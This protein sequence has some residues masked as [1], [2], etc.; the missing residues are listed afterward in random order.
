MSASREGLLDLRS[1]DRAVRPTAVSF[2]DPS[3][4]VVIADGHAFRVVDPDY[5]ET[6]TSFLASPLSSELVE[7]EMLINTRIVED[8]ELREQL[9]RI[10]MPQ[11]PQA[12]VLEH[13]HISFPT[14]P[15]EWP[16]EMLYAAGE[17]TLDLMERLLPEN[18][19]LKDASPYNIL[20]RGPKPV[21][22]DLLS[23]DKRAVEDSTW[24]A[25]AQFTRTFICP[26]LADKYFGVRLDQT[27]RIYRDGLQPEQVFRMSGMMRKLHPA[28][29][30]SISLPALLSRMDPNRYQTIYQPRQ[31]RSAELASFILERQLRGLR[32]KLKAAKPAAARK[33]SWADYEEQEAQK[34]R[35]L[36]AKKTFVERAIKEHGPGRVLDIG[37]NR[38]Y[39]SLLAA[40]AGCSVIAIDQ[41]PVVVGQLWRLA[42][43]EKLDVL[44]LV[45]DITRPTA[46][47]G[48]R[49]TETRGFLD[50]A[51]GSFQCVLMLAVIHHML[52][53]ERI[54]LEQIL[55]LAAELTTDMLIIEFV[56]PDDSMFRLI[57]RGNDRL[58]E[59]LNR[60]LFEDLSSKYFVIERTE[61]VGDSGRRLY[62]MR[63]A[64]VA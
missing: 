29:L 23:I 26:L 15:Y 47:L 11:C 21:F 28:L 42:A 9:I 62:Q 53:T 51:R 34:E 13:E 5:Q 6:I 49:N 8:R 20:Y 32:R 43:Q 56:P 52:V 48:W 33:S 45:T 14:Y 60:E 39:F 41:D 7:R 59:Y 64:R 44:P 46:G 55:Q 57:T 17:L 35:N 58:Y 2:R 4:R 18:L 12:L 1:D 27:F 40:K 63:R 30:T 16:P 54:P 38:G 22:I 25:Y 61:Q 36:P 3:G 19:V 10:A 24:L 31:R 37:C 50:R